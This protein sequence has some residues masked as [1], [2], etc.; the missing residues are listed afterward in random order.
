[1][2]P[3]NQ[4]GASALSILHEPDWTQTHSH[5]VGT[6]GRDARFMGITHSGDETTQKDLEEVAE[7]TLNELREKVKKGELVTVRDIM[8]KQIDFH[9]Q[10]PRVHPKFWRYVL[11]TTEDF[12]KQGQ[13]W[14]INQKKREEAEKKKKEK[15]EEENKMKEEEKKTKQKKK[16]NGDG[17]N[18][19]DKQDDQQ[20]HEQKD[21]AQEENKKPKRSTEEEA[22][23]QCL[24]YEQK[25]MCL[26][27][28]NDGKG[29]SPLADEDLPQQIDE[30]DQFSPDSWIPRSDKLIRLTGKHPLN[31]E[32]ELT[33]LFEAGF[34]TPSAIHYVRN[35]GAVPHLLWENHK[36]E[37]TAGKT[38]IFGMEELKNSFPS[39][40]IPIFIACDGNRRKELNM[41]RKTKGFNYTAAASGCAY[42]KGVLLRDVLLKADIQDLMEKASHKRFWVNFEGADT[43]SKGKYTTCMP[44]EYVIEPVND[45]I[46][47]YQMNDHPIPPDHGY[48]LRLMVPGWVGARSVKWLTKVWVTD[49]ENDNYYY[50]YD[51]RQLPS[52]VT[53]AESETAQIMYHH[54][55]TLCNAQML[56][57]II[58]R[59]AQGE[60]INLV[61][62]KKGKIYRV[63]GFAYSGN[64]NEISRVE[65]SLNGG[66]DWLYCVRKFPESP[67]RHGRKFWT[68]LH[69]HIDLDISK[70]IRAESIIVRATDEHRSTQP[71]EPIWNIEGMM[72]NCWY[73]VHPEVCENPDDGEA[74]LLFRHPVEAANGM[75]GW[76]KPSTQE[77]I[78][79]VKRKASAPGKQFTRQ[80]IEKH[81]TEDD[82]WIVVDGN[83]YDATSVLSWHPGGKGPIMAHAGAVHMDTTN[84]FT[85][86]HDNY[87]QGKLKECILGKVTERAMNHMKREAE[88]KEKENAQGGEKNPQ[89]ALDKH[90]W[91]QAKLVKKKRL[92]DDTQQYTFSLPPPAKKLGLETG[93]HVQVGFHFEDRLVVRPYTPVRPILEEEDDGTFDL[94]VK[95][96]FPDQDQPGGTMGNILD[97]LREGEEIE[98]KGPSG[99][100]RYLGHGTFAVDDK[101]YSFENVSLIVG[102]SGVTPGYQIIARILGNKQDKTKI[103]VIDANKSEGDILMKEKLDEFSKNS[104]GK[105]E[106]VH[107]LS[108]P[109]HDWKGL[110]GHVNEDIIKKHAFEP[111]DKNVALLCGPPTMIQKAALPALKDWGYDEDCN[112]FG[113]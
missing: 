26:M 37:I 67:I 104:E 98:V 93:Q 57:S 39:I 29:S 13:P 3:E 9:L 8:E 111:C 51:N 106:I 72:N 52:F 1:M 87:A 15:E 84:E 44:L 60:Q 32:V 105:F 48:P 81:Y 27:R 94:V 28:K 36:V 30:A 99:A 85:S 7:E 22:L 17:G 86:I 78:E 43:L 109:S 58:V 64:G 79:E 55:S 90:K 77:T 21:D 63:E 69:W 18:G 68:W 74:Y 83:V 49:Y 112:L 107:V 20:D 103:K 101:E 82:C 71:L 40:N 45:V 34:I 16:K 2:P 11:H 80:E 62:V 61:N 108:H 4:Q 41:I 66:N 65:I 12:I 53:D 54:P 97:C 76:M 47:A 23:L 5:R 75:N 31:A 10:K 100:I 35:H 96:Y 14:P 73:K 70:L 88:Q 91:T 24:Q 113:F 59:P 25:Y 6:R 50:I 95:T 46:L 110:S 42:W 56:N 33:T 102:G 89:I 19:Q 92:S 38:L